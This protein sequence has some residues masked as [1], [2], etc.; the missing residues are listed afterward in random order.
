VLHAPE[1]LALILPKLSPP[2]LILADNVL[3]HPT[4][5]A[6]YLAMVKSLKQLR[7]VLIPVGKA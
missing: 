5:I 1:Q 3:S 6:A 4:E 7:H 2:A